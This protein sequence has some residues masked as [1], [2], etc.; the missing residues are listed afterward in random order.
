MRASTH[1]EEQGAHGRRAHDDHRDPPDASTP[2]HLSAETLQ[3]QPALRAAQRADLRR[4]RRGPRDR[5][6]RRRAAVHPRGHD[7]A[8]GGLHERA[9]APAGGAGCVRRALERRAGDRGR[10]GRDRREL[11]VLLRQGAVARDADRAVRAGHRHA[12]GGAEGAGRAP[13][14]LVRRA[15][16]HVDLRPVRGERPLLPGA[17][18]AVRRRGPARDARARRR[19]RGWRELRLHNGTIYRWNRPIYD[20]VRGR[21]HLRVENRVLPAGPTVVDIAGQ[22]RVLLRPRAR[23]RRGGAAGVVAD[24]V[25]G[26]RG[27]L[28]RGRARRASRHA[29]TGRGSARCR[30][31]SSCSGGCCRWPTRGSSAGAST[32]PCATACW[33]SSSAAA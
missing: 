19:R 32:R 9:A 7:R 8:R 14:R 5:D 33:G 31:P 11:A 27:E 17:A 3:R 30:R 13:A 22:R 10:A 12:P 15:L 26:R 20:V 6:R 29:S 2:K 18:A 28:P 24:V 23:A 21:P 16:D 1:A 25:L 4:P